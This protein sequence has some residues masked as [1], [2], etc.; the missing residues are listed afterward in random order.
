MIDEKALS[1]MASIVDRIEQT[2]QREALQP[3][4]IIRFWLER[5][6]EVIV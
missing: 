6:K 2:N 4:E 3:S 1:V 5:Q